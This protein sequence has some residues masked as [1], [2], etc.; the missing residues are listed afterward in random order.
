MCQRKLPS[1]HVVVGDVG[2]V[3]VEQA[4]V[5]VIA[6]V[7]VHA[8]LGVEADGRFG[9]IGER[10]VAVVDE[11]T[12]GAEIAGD[13][14]I[15]PAVVVGVAV[16]EVERPAAELEADLL[17]HVGERAVVVVVIDGEA[18]AV[19][20]GLEALRKEA[21]RFRAGRRSPAGNNCRRTDRRS[22]RGR[23]RRRWR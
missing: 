23:N 2:D 22:R 17:G 4:V 20:G 16:A 18:A 19:V 14:E 1:A 12:V 11:E 13:I 21:R 6:P 10:A 5:V 7:D 3:D 15:V 8:L 9:L